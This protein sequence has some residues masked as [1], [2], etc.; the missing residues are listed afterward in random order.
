MHGIAS[1]T[2]ITSERRRRNAQQPMNEPEQPPTPGRL[3]DVLDKGDN[4]K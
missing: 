3:T 1:E 2:T 4:E